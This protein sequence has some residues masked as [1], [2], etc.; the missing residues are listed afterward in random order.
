RLQERRRRACRHVQGGTGKAQAEEVM[1]DRPRPRL[2]VERWTDPAAGDILEVAD[3]DVV[4][5]DLTAP[6]EQGW[7]SLES[8][9]GY[10]VATRTDVAAVAGGAQWLAGAALV[11]GCG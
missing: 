11:Q 8:A 9:H 5:L 10:Q 4:K 2:V 3:I 1:T 6:A 7:A